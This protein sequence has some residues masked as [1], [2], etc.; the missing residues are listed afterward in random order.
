MRPTLQ[1]EEVIAHVVWAAHILSY[2]TKN[3]N[4]VELADEADD[5]SD[6]DE[7]NDQETDCETEKAVI[8]SGSRVSVR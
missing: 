6:N 8:L 2:L 7:I 4:N 5:G 1:N 3:G